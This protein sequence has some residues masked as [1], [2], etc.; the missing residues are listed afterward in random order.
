M[1]EPAPAEA[2]IKLGF[3]ETI[4]TFPRSFW[5]GCGV[6]MFERLSYYGVRTVLPL[7]IAQADDPGG[8]HFRQAQKATIRPSSR[9]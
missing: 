4:K 9:R 7:Y 8:L 1:A 5:M 3:L 2:A 6:E